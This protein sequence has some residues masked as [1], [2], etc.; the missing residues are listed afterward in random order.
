MLDQPN[1]CHLRRRHP[2]LLSVRRLVGLVLLPILSIGFGWFF[3]RFGPHSAYG[4]N[5][6]ADDW[7]E[8]KEYAKA[9]AEYDDAIRLDPLLAGAYC[10]RG[11]AWLERKEYAR[12]MAD[13]NE[14]IRLDRRSTSAY[15][16]R[17]AAWLEKKD[18]DKAIADYNEA[19]RLEPDSPFAYYGRANAWF[20]KEDYDK[21]INDF[22]EDIR[23][24]SWVVQAFKDWPESIDDSIQPLVSMVAYAYCGR[25]AAWLA[26]KD[27]DKAIFD[28]SEALRLDPRLAAAYVGRGGVWRVKGEYAKA[29]C[30]ISAKPFDLMLKWLVLTAAVRGFGPHAPIHGFET[31]RRPS[32]RQQNRAN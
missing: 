26:K 18:Y 1:T 14:A 21:A 12:A 3:L 19:I 22:N 5:R 15:C 24:N 23:L 31:R 32:N 2:G 8:K 11:L 29:L 9:I 17:A 30:R 13:Y 20:G 6:R 28:Y 16:N 4:H 10:G 27:Y 25:G 7:F